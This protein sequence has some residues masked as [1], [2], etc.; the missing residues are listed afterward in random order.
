MFTLLTSFKPLCSG[1]GGVGG[2]SKIQKGRP[3]S[4]FVGH[5]CSPGSGS[6][7]RIR[8]NRSTDLI[9]YGSNPDPKQRV[10]PFPVHLADRSEQKQGS[11]KQPQNY[12]RQKIQVLKLLCVRYILKDFWVCVK[13]RRRTVP[14]S[15]F[16]NRVAFTAMYRKQRTGI[17]PVD[18]RQGGSCYCFFEQGRN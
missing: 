11:S 7:F 1:G 6:G 9:E 15:L 13:I 16:R 2:G 5:F 4:V 12:F 14:G 18:L 3:R 8:K 10:F 17:S